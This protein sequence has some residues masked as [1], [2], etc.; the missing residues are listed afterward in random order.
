M[1]NRVILVGRI[2]KEPELRTTAT[3]IN[4]LSFTLAFDNK[5]KNADGTRGSSFINCTAWRNNA[6]IIAKYCHKGSQIGIDGSLQ[7]RKYQ[8]RDGTNAS[9][10]EVVVSEVTLLGSKGTAQSN[11]Y[12]SQPEPA[13]QGYVQDDDTSVEDMISGG[14]G[15]LADDDLPF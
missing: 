2:T 14:D 7:E 10:I 8:R 15:D 4:V 11:S 13:N 12:N 9:V 1:I 3:G 6:D 5:N